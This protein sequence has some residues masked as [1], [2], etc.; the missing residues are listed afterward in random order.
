MSYLE[1]T[2][3]KLHKSDVKY[4]AARIKMQKYLSEINFKFNISNTSI[5]KRTTIVN[6]FKHCLYAESYLYK[7]IYISKIPIVTHLTI[8]KDLFNKKKQQKLNFKLQYL[9]K[10]A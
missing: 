7:F 5:S 4:G 8:V 9:K 3:I 2:R 1:L 10:N 6:T